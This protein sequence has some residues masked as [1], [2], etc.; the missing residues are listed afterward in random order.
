M[1]PGILSGLAS[2]SLSFLVGRTGTL[3]PIFFILNILVGVHPIEVLICIFLMRKD[4]EHH[5]KSFE[6][7]TPRA[8][9]SSQARAQTH[10]MTVT[11]QEP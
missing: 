3:T 10:A 4:F 2:L 1:V 8:C 7:G 6:G 11:T 9:R 5:I